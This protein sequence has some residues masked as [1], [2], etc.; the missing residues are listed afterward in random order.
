MVLSHHVTHNKQLCCNHDTA[1]WASMASSELWWELH[2]VEQ[3]NYCDLAFLTIWIIPFDVMRYPNSHIHLWVGGHKAVYRAINEFAL[4]HVA[5]L[6]QQSTPLVS[7]FPYN[8]TSYSVCNFPFFPLTGANSSWS[9]SRSRHDAR[10][11]SHQTLLPAGK[12]DV[13]LGGEEKNDGTEPER[14]AHTVSGAAVLSYRHRV[15]ADTDTLFKCD[16]NQCMPTLSLSC[17]D[18]KLLVLI[19]GSSS[20]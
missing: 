11:S 19:L 16:I 10:G 2:S 7:K 4:F 6:G 20:S 8:Y 3:H 9:Y 5:L 18:N 1:L 17:S 14:R 12:Q 13:E 15:S